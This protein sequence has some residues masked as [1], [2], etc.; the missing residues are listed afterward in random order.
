MA[1]IG[2]L[3]VT[4]GGVASGWVI[5]FLLPLAGASLLLPSLLVFFIC[6]LAVL[7]ILATPACARSR[8]ARRIRSCSRP[9]CTERL[10][11]Q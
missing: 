11:S 1:A 3:V 8:A 4:G 7:T 5:L 2:V 6:A 9:A 10:S